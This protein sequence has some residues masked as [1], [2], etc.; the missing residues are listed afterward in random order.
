MFYD[1]DIVYFILRRHGRIVS[2]GGYLHENVFCFGSKLLCRAFD[3]FGGNFGFFFSVN[4]L[5]YL[6][7]YLVA[8]YYRC[9]IVP[10][11][12]RFKGAQILCKTFLALTNKLVLL[13]HRFGIITVSVCSVR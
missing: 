11:A 9:L 6:P 13:S 1:A 7:A 10:Q 3:G 5:S 2:L 4:S 12:V 8:V